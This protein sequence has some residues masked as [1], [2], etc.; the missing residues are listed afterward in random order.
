MSS[1]ATSAIERSPTPHAE[2]ANSAVGC[3]FAGA[4]PTYLGLA[5][6]KPNLCAEQCERRLMSGSAGAVVQEAL[7]TF[8][9]GDYDGFLDVLHPEVE[10]HPSSSVVAPGAT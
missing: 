1:T 2:G 8:R 4:G 6:G 3:S 5:D 9:A 10:W 7:R